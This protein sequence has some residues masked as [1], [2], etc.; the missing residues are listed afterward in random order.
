MKKFFSL[1]LITIVASVSAMVYA[2][3]PIKQT[4]LP[5]AAQTFLSKHFP[6]DEVLKA[7]KEQGRRGMEY[8]VDLKSGTEVDFQENGDW[9]E[10]KAARGNAV[11][12]TIIPAAIAK[13]VSTNFNGQSIVEISRKRGGYEVELSN[14]TELKLTEDA[15][16]MPARQGGGRGNRR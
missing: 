10:V 13:Y 9:K 15:K 12:E 11:P 6:G 16:P 14:G 7:E 5:K 4:E 8:E 2:G 1:M 3:T